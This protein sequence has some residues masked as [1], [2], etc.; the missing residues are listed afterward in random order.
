MISPL[1]TYLA[2]ARVAELRAMGAE[3]HPRLMRARRRHPPAT[4]GLTMRPSATRR[5]AGW[6]LVS[7]GLRLA[8]GSV[9]GLR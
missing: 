2:D 1:V 4:S 7:M 3:G 6:L 8:V 9:E 5:R